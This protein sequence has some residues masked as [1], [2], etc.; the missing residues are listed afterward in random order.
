MANILKQIFK[1]LFEDDFQALNAE[2]QSLKNSLASVKQALVLKESDINRL[3]TQI[4]TI[5]RELEQLNRRKSKLEE[6]INILTEELAST[7]TELIEKQNKI[8]SLNDQVELW[9]HTSEEY[10]KKSE[11]KEE[12]L[13]SANKELFN[14][15][16]KIEV[17]RDQ[18][19]GYKTSIKS[20]LQGKDTQ[21]ED[22]TSENL[23]LSERLSVIG[24]EKNRLAEELTILADN[25]NYEIQELKELHIQEITTKENLITILNTE[26]ENLSSQ[27]RQLAD[28]HVQAI[29]DIE[30]EYSEK[31]SEKENEIEILNSEKDET[32]DSL[33]KKISEIEN[34]NSKLIL[35][36]KEQ[37]DEIHCLSISKQNIE[38]EIETKDSEI[39]FLNNKLTAIQDSTVNKELIDALRKDIS[40]KQDEITHLED[41]IQRLNESI[42]DNKS[43]INEL[44]N[45]LHERDRECDALKASLREQEEKYSHSRE[46]ERQL[47]NAKAEIESL[48]ELINSLPS[49]SDLSER[50]KKIKRLENTIETLKA[51][52]ASLQKSDEPENL[53]TPQIPSSPQDTS[54]PIEQQITPETSQTPSESNLPKE[55]VTPKTTITSSAP[56]TPKVP[57]VTTHS[58]LQTSNSSTHSSTNEPVNNEAK[59]TKENSDSKGS[60]I[61]HKSRVRFRKPKQ[62]YIKKPDD[63]ASGKILKKK[64]FPKIENDNIY[65]SSNRL[66]DEVYDCRTD[67]YVSANSIFLRWTAEEIS[68]LRHDLDEASRG[69]EP[70]LICPCCRQMVIISSRSVGFGENRRDVQFFM[71][72][73]KN[74][75]CDLKRDY[76]YDD[77]AIDGIGTR[78]SER[79]DFL[80]ELKE[81]V[82]MALSSGIGSSKEISDVRVSE[83][84][85]SDEL[86]IMRRRFADISASYK[87]H[88]IVFEL[89]TPKTNSSKLHD[90]DIF[91]LINKRQVFWILGLNSKVDYNELKRSV[92]KDIMYTNRRNVFVFDIEAQE[93]TIRRGE[94]VLKCNW[95]D[96]ND[97]WYFQNEKNGQN[98]KLITL[99][100][101]QFD[102]DSCRPYYFDADEKYYSINPTKE[103]PAKLTREEL[104]KSVLESWNYRQSRDAAIKVMYKKGEGVEAFFDGDKWGFKYG[105]LIFIEPSYSEE[106]EI[107]GSYA[108]VKVKDKYGIVNRFGEIKLPPKFDMIKIISDDLILYSNGNDWYIFGIIEAIASY[109]DNDEISIKT[110]SKQDNIYNL[111]IKKHLYDGQRSEEFYFFGDQLFHK[112][113]WTGRWQLMSSHG[114]KIERNYWD[115]LEITPDKRLK[116][117][118]GNFVTYLSSD[119]QTE[120]KPIIDESKIIIQKSLPNGYAIVKDEDNYYGIVDNNKNIVVDLKYDNIEP[121]DDTYLYLRYHSWGKWGVMSYE[122]VIITKPLYKSIDSSCNG[123]FNVTISD[124]DKSWKTLSGKIDIK[125]NP[126]LEE[127]KELDNEFKIFK[128]FDRFGLK[129]E[130]VVLIKPSYQFL[131]KWGTNK[132]I[133]KKDDKFGIVDFRGNVIIPFEYSQISPF[134][135]NYATVSKGTITYKINSDCQVIADE[136]INL[137]E[138]FKKIKKDGKWGILAPNGSELVAPKYNEISTFRGRL[139]GIINGKLIK[140]SAYYP[141]RLQMTGINKRING[142]DMVQVSTVLFRINP[143][144]RGVKL[145]EVSSIVLCNFTSTMKYPTAVMCKQESLSKKSKHIDKPEDFIIGDNFTV[146]VEYIILGYGNQKRKFKGVDI[147]LDDGRISHIYRSDFANCG[148]DISSIKVGDTFNIT[149]LG[150]NDELDR[151]I[152]KVENPATSAIPPT[153]EK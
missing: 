97:E 141:Y 79:P 82:R 80:N 26:K 29:T 129:T 78:Q 130:L 24:T 46:T 119:G 45:Q 19:N 42:S 17:L 62:P 44:Q 70:Y 52:L 65:S 140:L 116:L 101:I 87:G 32:I 98:G 123:G 57:I 144:R 3:R 117:I 15:K 135:D 74:V 50:D 83:W 81:V 27:I 134:E 49:E 25:K 41:N 16:K 73:N 58:A 10:Q 110:I 151:T 106:P 12:E 36:I 13:T 137:Q 146:K 6:K 33:N 56:S 103:R 22:L 104:K 48:K 34:Q 47:T 90:R 14:I 72:A 84:I 142:K 131:D 109:N 88:K 95:Q 118:N 30:S 7:R 99:D 60:P 139:I 54:T 102:D 1:G 92:A 75:P 124:P 68:H 100:E 125:G 71:H 39:E 23:N 105:D 96:E 120:E 152:W 85:K 2:N 94:L 112:D 114:I 21:I 108:I 66:I 126:I 53:S 77:V 128:S 113:K 133:A 63:V 11:G 127:V 8:V 51:K 86:P 147:K 93:E 18:F 20:I 121:I 145:G 150:Y 31:L 38:S 40:G 43:A 143:D 69:N 61:E 89:V 67:K 28:R 5:N 122:G 111:I 64:N 132:L 55:P 35:S 136:I 138:G 37:E 148:I 76:T 59:I 107:C 149:K 4:S 115:N 153:I 9:K 91:Y